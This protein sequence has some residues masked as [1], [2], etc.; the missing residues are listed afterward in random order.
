VTAYWKFLRPGRISPFTRYAW[1]RPGEWV[2]A[3]HTVPCHR[4]LHACRRADLPYW[5]LEELWRVE[6]DGPVA[7]A[8]TKVVARRARLLAPVRGWD[9]DTARDLGRACLGRA[10]GHAAD[11]LA[12]AGLAA[13]SHALRAVADGGPV[14]ALGAAAGEAA[15]VAE[16]AGRRGAAWLCGYVVEAVRSWDGGP[17]Q[18][19]ASIA[20]IAVRAAN[21]RSVPP[22]PD[23]ER[24][25]QADWLGRRLDLDRSA[26]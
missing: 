9:G 10:A 20:Y 19:A 22:E 23:A 13:S 24:D 2:E 8:A 17:V 12:A 16:A 18:S 26:G 21:H 11:E 4:G 1:P 15:E 3:G 5:L 6:L 25:W 14:P 7:S